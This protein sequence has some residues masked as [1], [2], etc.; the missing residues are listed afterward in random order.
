MFKYAALLIFVLFFV[1]PSKVFALEGSCVSYPF[2]QTI[3]APKSVLR[4]MTFN[5]MFTHFDF[6][7]PRNTEVQMKQ[8]AN[9]IKQENL[10]V[11]FLQEMEYVST[12][13]TDNGKPSKTKFYCPGVTSSACC[14]PYDGSTLNVSKPFPYKN[15]FDYLMKEL[16][17]IGYPMF[18]ASGNYIEGNLS[19]IE[20]SGWHGYSTTL[21][22]Y[23]I[24]NTIPYYTPEDRVVFRTDINIGGKLVNFYNLHIRGSVDSNF[25]FG[26]FNGNLMP[27]NSVL[28]GDFNFSTPDAKKYS[29][30]KDLIYYPPDEVGGLAD[31]FFVRKPTSTQGM[32]SSDFAL[33][34]DL[35]VE[36]GHN[37]FIFSLD[38]SKVPTNYK[39]GD[40]NNDLV[41]NISDIL[42][43]V[44]E[45]FSGKI[46]TY[47]FDINYDGQ[48]NVGDVFTLVKNIF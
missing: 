35:K 38:I 1:F 25:I 3:P 11:V 26:L 4:G 8:I 15:P 43:L 7:T 44:K 27:Y 46:F 5:R 47:A 20:P 14:I 17:A 40:I 13:L 30:E 41:T 6:D 31:A 21:S 45:L 12:D 32:V 29:A 39:P 23:P 22:K 48:I 18:Y 28:I 2:P 36:E 9:V 24:V 34:G 10:D 37:A 42:I 19:I 16:I 33:R